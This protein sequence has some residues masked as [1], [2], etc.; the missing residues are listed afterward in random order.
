MINLLKKYKI[1]LLLAGLALV[2]FLIKIFWANKPA[3]PSVV[4]RLPFPVFTQANITNRTINYQFNFSQPGNLP[5]NL[6]V[7]KVSDLKTETFPEIKPDYVGSPV[8]SEDSVAIQAAKTFLQEKGIDDNFA[9]LSQLQYRQIDK[10]ETFSASSSAQADIFVVN[11]WPQIKDITVVSDTPQSP[12]T[13]IWVGKNGKTEKAFATTFSFT[14]SGSFSLRSLQTASQDL[15]SQKGTLVW[16][17]EG[18]N[19]GYLPP[20]TVLGI[21]LQKASLAYYLP[22]TNQEIMEP[23][24]VFEGT[25][26]IQGEGAIK[27]AVYLPAIEEKYFLSPEP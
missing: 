10:S 9:G 22:S 16:L 11:F 7:Y 27:A 1:I 12:L 23:V 26:Q 20:K 14:E 15:V 17:D 13:S 18:E 21:T 8:V 24:F 6:P 2:L 4:E 25:A 5:E 19:Y 3:T